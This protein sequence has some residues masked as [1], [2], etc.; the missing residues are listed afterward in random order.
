M[1]FVK[2][3]FFYM[4]IQ[5]F[6]LAIVIDALGGIP[7]RRV[8]QAEKLRFINNSCSID[9]HIIIKTIFEYF[10]FDVCIL[11]EYPLI[12]VQKLH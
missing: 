5:K 6:M 10:S 8:N 3:D 1:L 12:I 9:L 4:Q 2:D 7:T 11:N